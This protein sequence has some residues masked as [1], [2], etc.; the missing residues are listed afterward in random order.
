MKTTHSAQLSISSSVMASGA[1]VEVVEEKN[2][3][4]VFPDSALFPDSA[5]D[6]E[7]LADE[8]PVTR[9]AAIGSG[10]GAN[11]LIDLKPWRVTAQ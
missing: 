1:H 8:V 2:P 5:A 3:G 4:S 11:S 10:E 7:T 9:D 6:G